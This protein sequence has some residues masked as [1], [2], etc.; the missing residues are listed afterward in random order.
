MHDVILLF[1]SMDNTILCVQTLVHYEKFVSVSVR[2]R[3]YAYVA[4]NVRHAR[5]LYICRTSAPARHIAA[6]HLAAP[7]RVG[8]RRL[9][10]GER[11]D[12]RNACDHAVMQCHIE[13]VRCRVIQNCSHT[14]SVHGIQM[15]VHE[16]C[17]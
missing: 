1:E 7:V 14:F 13:S 5:H 12:T 3:H 15:R 2:D 4:D 11:L 8:A 17:K 10:R 6:R 9:E 16:V